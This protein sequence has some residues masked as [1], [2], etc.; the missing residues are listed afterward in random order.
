MIFT[1]FPSDC[2]NI[3]KGPQKCPGP[4]VPAGKVT[5]VDPWRGICGPLFKLTQV[6]L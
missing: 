5:E 3:F 6:T 2:K 1:F 4:I